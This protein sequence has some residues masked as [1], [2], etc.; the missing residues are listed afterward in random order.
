MSSG[1][2]PLWAAWTE[3]HGAPLGKG[4]TRR[5]HLAHRRGDVASGN[6]Q[7]PA[8]SSCPDQGGAAFPG[9]EKAS[10]CDTQTPLAG[11]KAVGGPAELRRPRRGQGTLRI[12]PSTRPS[13][14]ATERPA[15]RPCHFQEDRQGGSGRGRSP[16]ALRDPLRHPAGSLLRAWL[17]SAGRKRRGGRRSGRVVVVQR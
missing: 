5:R 3:S 15:R 9:S 10:G 8:L 12:R 11:W 16:P 4:L 7:S 2:C 14:S 6:V 1:M 13:G 17:W